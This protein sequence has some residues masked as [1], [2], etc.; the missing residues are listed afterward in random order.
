MLRYCIHAQPQG[1]LEPVLLFR[2]TT[3][4][5]GEKQASDKTEGKECTKTTAICDLC[6]SPL[7]FS[8]WSV[9]GWWLQPLSTPELSQTGVFS[10]P[11]IPFA[12]RKYK[13]EKSK[14]CIQWPGV[15]IS[16]Q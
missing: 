14:I 6:V 11:T 4:G 3:A 7:V 9:G 8:W 13:D 1:T 12:Y 2:S 16:I 10:S 5:H 15:Y